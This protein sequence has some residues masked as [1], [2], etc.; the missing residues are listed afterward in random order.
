MQLTIKCLSLRNKIKQIDYGKCEI[1]VDIL[2]YEGIY[3]ISNYGR[4]KTLKH[5]SKCKGYSTKDRIV[6]DF[7]KIVNYNISLDIRLNLDI[8]KSCY[9]KIV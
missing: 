8:E 1:W 4:V 9:L 3:K 5:R 6:E 2:G 7:Y